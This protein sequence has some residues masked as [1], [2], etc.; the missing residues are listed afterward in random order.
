[1]GEEVSGVM[2]KVPWGLKGHGEDFGF[3]LSEAGLEER[4]DVI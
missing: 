3:P 1:M 4:R 2:G